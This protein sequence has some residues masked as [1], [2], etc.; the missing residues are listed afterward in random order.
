MNR[1]LAR[2]LPSGSRNRSI[3]HFD[4]LRARQNVADQEVDE[5]QSLAEPVLNWIGR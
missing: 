5:P 3:R 1:R 4:N 2:F